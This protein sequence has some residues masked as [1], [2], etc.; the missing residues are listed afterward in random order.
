MLRSF[1]KRNRVQLISDSVEWYSPEQF[2]Y[3]NFSMGMILKNIENR[4]AINKTIKVVAISEYLNNYF[5]N[6]DYKSIR[7]PVIL[8]VINTSC[9]KTVR[10]DK[11]VIVYAGSPGKKDYFKEIAEGMLMLSPNELKQIEFRIIGATKQQIIVNSG[12]MEQTIAQLSESLRMFGRMPREDVLKNL[13]QAD[14]TVLL[15]SPVQRYAKAG[16]PTKVVESLAS[17]TPVILN[18]TSDLGQYVKDMQEGI[19]VN[20]CTAE[21]FCTA[22]KKA[23]ALNAEQKREMRNKA[24]ECAEKNFDYRNYIQIIKNEI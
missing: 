7:I 24:R 17:A 13:E 10:D 4:I 9:R 5:A 3:G 23:L 12:V 2:R 11:L 1:A 15:R 16:F 21:A 19:L 6:K 18:L 22:I 8:D 14:F 20:D